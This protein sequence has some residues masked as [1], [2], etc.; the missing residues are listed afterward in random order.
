MK[1][2]DITNS[3][4]IKSF[5]INKNQFYCLEYK[6]YNFKNFN[7]KINAP[8]NYF[9]SNFCY[10]ED[11]RFKC[12]FKEEDI[13]EIES[14]LIKFKINVKVYFIYFFFYLNFIF[15]IF[16]FFNFIFKND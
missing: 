2:Q 7:M 14:L 10:E 1:E 4:Q 5:P 16:K 12:F 3:F 6:N 11:E 13:K 8:E 15:Y 9:K